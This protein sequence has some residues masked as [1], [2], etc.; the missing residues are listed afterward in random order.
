MKTL[1][2]T[3]SCRLHYI[4]VPQSVPGNLQTYLVI[5]SEYLLIAIGHWNIR[6][7]PQFYI[8]ILAPAERFVPLERF[9]DFEA[10]AN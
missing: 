10:A 1:K 7:A 5:D 9:N 6:D 8:A 4:S 3:P 2:L